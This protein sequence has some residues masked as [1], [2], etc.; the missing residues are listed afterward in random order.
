MAGIIALVS[1]ILAIIFIA[2]AVNSYDDSFA[3]AG[4]VFVVVCIISFCVWLFWEDSSTI[5]ETTLHKPHYV[6]IIDTD[7]TNYNKVIIDGVMYKLMF[8]WEETVTTLSNCGCGDDHNESNPKPNIKISTNR[9]LMVSLSNTGLSIDIPDNVKPIVVDGIP[10]QA[11]KS[12]EWWNE[13]K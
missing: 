6:H 11:V 4:A 2:I 1:L 8:D 13:V 3:G 7:S 10:E 9:E 12:G 5:I